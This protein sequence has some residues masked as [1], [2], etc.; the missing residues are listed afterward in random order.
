MTKAENDLKNIELVMKA[1]D[2]PFDTVCFHAQQAAEKYIKA[3]LTFYGI[4]FGKSHDLP[5]L[6][7]LLPSTSRVPSEVGDLSELTDAAVIARYPGEAEEF[8]RETAEKLLKQAQIVKASVLAE[9]R[10]SGLL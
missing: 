1:A 3:L 7:L 5:E 9:L 2:A 4:A 8:N 10:R 6:A